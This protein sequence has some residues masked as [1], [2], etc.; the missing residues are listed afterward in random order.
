MASFCIFWI[1]DWAQSLVHLILEIKF[2]QEF[3]NL[4]DLKQY[5]NHPSIFSWSQF[6]QSSFL[7]KFLFSSKCMLEAKWISFL[8]THYCFEYYIFQIFFILYFEQ[9]CIQ[10]NCL[11]DFEYLH[12]LNLY[13]WFQFLQTQNLFFLIFLDL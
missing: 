5:D 3:L 11:S 13:Q 10:L 1:L 9:F 2:N 8:G 7:Y 4:Q 12:I 6:F